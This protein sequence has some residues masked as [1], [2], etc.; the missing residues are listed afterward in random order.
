MPF[1]RETM[2]WLI[3]PCWIIILIMVLLGLFA[4]ELVKALSTALSC[5]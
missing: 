2:L 3:I 1:D 5:S 4:G